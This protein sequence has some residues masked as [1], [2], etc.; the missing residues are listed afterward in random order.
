VLLELNTKSIFVSRHV[1]Y[2]EHIFPY[3]NPNP[4]FRWTYH[5]NHPIISDVDLESH[6]HTPDQNQPNQHQNLIIFE[7]DDHIL[8][9]NMNY[10]PLPDITLP[11]HQPITLRK[12]TKN[13]HKP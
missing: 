4:S 5:S 6:S 11:E 12:S 8:S 10:N 7:P 13:T 3:H 9:P 2:H 1:P